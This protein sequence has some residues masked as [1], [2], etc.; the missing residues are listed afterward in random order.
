MA[1]FADCGFPLE[2]IP[3]WPR[4]SSPCCVSKRNHFQPNHKLTP[5][6][7]TTAQMPLGVTP[8]V[9]RRASPSGFRSVARQ[10]GG[11]RKNGRRRETVSHLARDSP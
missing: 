11:I 10:V 7:V 2:G 4:L 3:V 8:F 9:P 1:G 6:V 5:I